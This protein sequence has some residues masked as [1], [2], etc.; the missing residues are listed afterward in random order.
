GMAARRF[1]SGELAERVAVAGLVAMGLFSSLLVGTF[2]RDL[3]LIAFG[4]VHTAVP[5]WFSFSRLE[6]V[7]AQAVPLIALVVT[8]V[9]FVNARRIARVVEVSVPIAGL[10][11][12]L[13]GFSIAQISDVHVGVTIRREYVQGIVDAVNRLDADIVAITGDLVDGSVPQLREH[14]APLAQ[15]KARH[16]V[17]F[18][19]G[20][21]EY[22]SGAL[23]WMEELRRLGINVLHNAHAVV[24]HAGEQLVVAGVPDFSAGHFHDDHASD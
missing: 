6:R 16:G 24:E 5:A 12:A 18:V 9:G 8:A 7:S 17:F 14:V 19:T 21:H 3:L 13:E 15:L 23:P 20:N 1:L 2:L 22:Y 4:I 10:P 11:P